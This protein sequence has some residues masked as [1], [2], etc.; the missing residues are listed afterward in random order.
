M[1]IALIPE[2]AVASLLPHVLPVLARAIPYAHGRFALDH[3]REEIINGE[4]QLWV[5]FDPSLA[6]LRVEGAFLTAIGEYPGLKVLRIDFLG[7]ENLSDWI[8][9]AE[10]ML[11]RYARDNGCERLEMTGR[12]GWLTVLDKLG[13]KLAFI[14]LEKEVG[15][16]HEQR[17][18][19]DAGHRE[20]DLRV[21]SPELPATA[22]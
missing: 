22:V 16:K 14:T 6:D 21:N 19:L 3:L 20:D 15:T 7:G 11:L 8:R 1:Q 4:R 9:A 2:E 10:E 17:Q 18:G 13:W 12:L 5:A